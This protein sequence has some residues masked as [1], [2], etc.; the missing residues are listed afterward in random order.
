[1]NHRF[2]YAGVF[3][4]AIGAVLVA[5]D[6]NAITNDTLVQVLRLWPLALIAIGLGL[7][8]RRSRIGFGTGMLAAAMPGLLLGGVF[9][10]APRLPNSCTSPLDAAPAYVQSGSFDNEPVGVDIQ[11]GCGTLDLS[12][13]A[14]PGWSFTA[15]GA[16]GRIPHI[17]ANPGSLS[18]DSGGG[19]GFDA[20]ASGQDAW[21][22]TLPQQNVYDTIGVVANANRASLD[23][24]G[25]SVRDLLITGNAARVR[26]DAAQAI[27]AAIN[28]RIR[29]GELRVDL[30]ATTDLAASI[31]VDAGRALICAPDGLGLRFTFGGSLRDVTINGLKETG[32]SWESPDYDTAPHHADLDVRVDLGGIEINPTGGC[33]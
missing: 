20:F 32:S 3:L 23:L 33:S 30:P 27:L 1:M 22:L 12:M 31:R 24:A 14:G 13:G 7:A 28:A 25:A 5:A 4:V 16:Q 21:Q 9:A 26:V 29:L 2:V 11:T 6:L 19:S 15:S 10:A 18:I 8:L 17:G